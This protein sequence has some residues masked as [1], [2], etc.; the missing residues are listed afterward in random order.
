MKLWRLIIVL[1]VMVS[2]SIFSM[3]YIYISHTDSSK[4]EI[5]RLIVYP[6]SVVKVLS[7]EFTNIVADY[8][9]LSTMVF[10]GQKLMDRVD[11]KPEEWR[12]M[13]IALNLI[14]DLDPRFMDPYLAAETSL[15]WDAGMV[16]ETNELL[17]KAVAH[18]PEDYRPNFY[19]WFNYYYF[20]NDPGT[21][22]IYLQKAARMPGSPSYFKTLAARM[23]LDSGQILNGIV[24]LQEM[25]GET[26]ETRNKIMLQKRLD[27]LK[28]IYSLE[29][30]IREYEKVFRRSPEK[31]DDLVS[32]G[33]I[34]KIPDDPY[35]G[36]FYI[37]KEGRVYSTSKLTEATKQ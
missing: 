6:S 9:M 23:S 4:S 21:A 20:L 35:G 29:G 33:I 28:A 31:L 25:I 7:L 27:A 19:L 37:T 30:K 15:P 36:E 32:Q 26:N 2:V 14:T 8:L 34:K 13:Y 18:R 17:L 22:V 12:L 16:G 3:H 11:V 24:F 5:S 1:I 10:H